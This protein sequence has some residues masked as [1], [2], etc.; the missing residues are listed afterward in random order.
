MCTNNIR[1]ELLITFLTRAIDSIDRAF[2]NVNR[3]KTRQATLAEDMTTDWEA[4][5]LIARLL[6]K[7]YWTIMKT[8]P[9]NLFI[10]Q[11]MEDKLKPEFNGKGIIFILP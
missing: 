10:P 2:L 5:A 6:G 4:N 3:Q 8:T 9:E 11:N 7:A 1:I